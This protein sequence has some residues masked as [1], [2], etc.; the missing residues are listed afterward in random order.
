MKERSNGSIHMA[1]EK[2]KVGGKGGGGVE[3]M[4]RR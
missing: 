4:E 1:W 3:I 2:K